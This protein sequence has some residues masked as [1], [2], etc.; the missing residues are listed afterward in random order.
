MSRY[1]EI[2]VPHGANKKICKD[3]G[4]VASTVRLALKGVSDTELSRTIRKRALDFYD[5]VI[6][7]KLYK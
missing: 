5:G 3:L 7:N 4:V 6:S 1:K 2:F